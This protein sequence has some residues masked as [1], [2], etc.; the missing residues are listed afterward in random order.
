MAKIE[1]PETPEINRKPSIEECSIACYIDLIIINKPKLFQLFQTS[2][3][4]VGTRVPGFHK[5]DSTF[6]IY[7]I[8]AKVGMGS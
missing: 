6:Y 7:D 5:R 3:R 4:T 2:S 8:H 1:N